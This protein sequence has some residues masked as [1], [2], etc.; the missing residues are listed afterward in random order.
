[1]ATNESTV[2]DKSICHTILDKI[3]SINEKVITK[4]MQL[5]SEFMLFSIYILRYY[6]FHRVIFAFSHLI[7]TTSQL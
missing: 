3:N 5:K 6:E 7:L 2:E 4:V 1:M